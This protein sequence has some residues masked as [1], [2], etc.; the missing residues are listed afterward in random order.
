MPIVAIERIIQHISVT[1][2]LIEECIF[3]CY[4]KLF[5]FSFNCFVLCVKVGVLCRPILS[6]IICLILSC[7][8]DGK[9]IRVEWKAQFMPH[10]LLLSRWIAH[11]EGHRQVAIN[12]TAYFISSYNFSYEILNFYYFD[13]GTRFTKRQWERKYFSLRCS[14]QLCKIWQTNNFV[15]FFF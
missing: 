5:L 10:S 6:F 1:L 9:L 13:L 14:C 11:T 4:E 7:V 12:M 15:K 3:L 8:G 2:S